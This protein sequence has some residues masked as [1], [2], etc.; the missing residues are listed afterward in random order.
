MDAQ[1]TNSEPP[2]CP[3]CIKLAKQNAALEKR[4]AALEAKL[5]ALT[6]AG[7]RQAAP[8][9]KAPPKS[10]PQ[11]PGR[12]SG[13]D[14]GTKAFRR[15]P[16]VIDEVHHAPL[17]DRCPKCGGQTQQTHIAT[18]YQTEIPRR[19]I[20]RQFNI[21]VGRCTCCQ[22]RVQGRHA[23]QTSDALGCCASQLGAEAQATAVILNK[24]LGLSHGKVKRFFKSLFDISL[25]RGGSC[26]STLRAA[27][28]LT[29]NYQAIVRHVQA[30]PT[31]VADE[32]GW[33]IGGHPAWLHTA[34][35]A[36]AAAY[37]VHAHRGFEAAA[38]LIGAGYAGKLVHDGW[39]SY[40]RFLRAVHQ[41]CLQ[42][43]IRRCSDLLLT[44]T[45]G[46]VHFPRQIKA[47]LQT[48]LALRDRRD[49]GRL[50]PSTVTRYARDL[51]Q[52]LLKLIAPIKTHAGNER[53]AKHLWRY[54]DQVF[55]FLR[56]AGV[57]ATNWRA[58]QAL[59]PAV[60][61][62]KV[63][64]GNRTAHGAAAQGVLSSVLS[65]ARLRGVES[66][67][68]IS[69]VLCSLPGQRPMLLAGPSG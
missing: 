50:A 27:E 61:N 63:W 7:K 59:R 25:S 58:E 10:D 14:Y 41:T 11:K 44:A 57:D 22:A 24:E 31:L 1:T 23:L 55:T 13:E 3:G 65:T 66:L 20:H 60:V 40:D 32:T 26:Q 45:G 51:Q 2:T 52:Q 69:Q 18:Q 29:G 28:R 35:C 42:H 46:A 8:F 16:A 64:G 36:D 62:R 12:K 53:F 33:R 5:Q 30:S 34:A 49:A 37:L 38:L 21:A 39:S 67:G 48:A 17:P 9:S 43:L 56:K 47:I 15:A 19:P 4:L 54:R 68:F 6:R